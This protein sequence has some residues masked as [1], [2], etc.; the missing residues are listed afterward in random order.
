MGLTGN[1]EQLHLDGDVLTVLG[2]STGVDD[3]ELVSRNVAIHQ[4][5]NVVHGPA[6]SSTLKWTV[7]PPLAAPGFEA[8]EALALGVETYFAKNL[9]EL[10]TFVTFTWSQIVTIA[11]K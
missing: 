3:G 6:S 10:P 9:G 11:G 2:S 8:G 7:D 5:G 1:F 4:D